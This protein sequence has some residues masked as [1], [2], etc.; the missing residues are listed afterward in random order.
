MEK[1]ISRFLTLGT[2]ISTYGLLI[3][4]LIQIFARFFLPKTPPWTEEASRLFFI[5]AISFSAGLALKKG[6]YIYLD[7][8]FN[9]LPRKVQQLL[10]IFIPVSVLWLFL[11]MAIFAI[12]FIYLGYW[13]KS[14][15]MNIRMAYIFSSMFIM[16]TAISYFSVLDII[17]SIKKNSL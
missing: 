10:L 7:V 3:S 17:A 9:R 2:Y 4:V 12:Q 14:P 1:T 5:Y 6:A 16:G 15:S 8:F 13:E 11:L